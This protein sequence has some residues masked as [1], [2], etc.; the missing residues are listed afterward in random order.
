MHTNEE[1]REFSVCFIHSECAESLN[2][3]QSYKEYTTGVCWC[4]DI[5]LIPISWKM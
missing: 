5:S 1:F 4:S 2:L 3:I